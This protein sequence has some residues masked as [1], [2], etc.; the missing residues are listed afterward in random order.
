MWI[1]PLLA[2]AAAAATSPEAVTLPRTEVHRITAKSNGVP[3]EIR[4]ALPPGY[5]GGSRK[6]GTVYVLD[7][8]YSFAIARNVVEHLSDRDHLEPLL[9]VGIAYDGPLRYR[10]DRTR[11]YTPSH[12]PRGGYGEEMQKHSGGGPEFLEF[13]SGELIPFIDER[14][15]T[16]DDRRALVGHSYGGLF[17]SW[18][19]LTTGSTLFD[20][21]IIVSPSLWYHD[22]EMFELENKLAE[23][24]P[25]PAGRVYLS[26]GSIENSM[27]ATDLRRFE[28]ALRERK[29]PGLALRIEVLDGETHN[30]VFPSAFSR[31]LRWAFEGR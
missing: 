10:L 23:K 8:D 18:T 19:L 2:A 15:R 13:L 26:V 27:M 3:Y 31:G 25:H 5:A 20:R 9:V 30:S 4:V 22:R 14:Y 6:Y 16:A 21:F 29:H 1:L 11:D 12:S 7:A 17:A 24:A 28:K